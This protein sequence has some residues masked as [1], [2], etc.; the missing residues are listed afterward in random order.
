VV[1]AVV[2]SFVLV[3]LIALAFYVLGKM[4]GWCMERR[5]RSSRRGRGGRR[6]YLGIIFTRD[7]DGDRVDIIEE[8]TGHRRPGRISH[9]GASIDETS[10]LLR[11]N[12][13]GISV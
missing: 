3:G 1:V 6:S 12:N 8:E 4:I 10:P 13:Q 2:S 5:S 9:N 7:M 11:G